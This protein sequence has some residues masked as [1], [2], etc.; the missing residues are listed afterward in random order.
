MLDTL[1]EGIEQINSVKK[2]ISKAWELS[3][4]YLGIE[5]ETKKITEILGDHENLFINKNPYHNHYHLAEVIFTSAVLLKAEV[6]SP[7]I[8]NHGVM[9]LFAATFHDVE[10][11]GR[12]NKEPF[13]AE[14]VSSTFFKQWWRNNS[15]FVE[16]IVSM[17][18]I[19]MEESIKELILF[20]EF[21]EGAKK[22]KE[23]YIKRKDRVAFSLEYFT[24]LKKIL[25]EAD[26]LLNFLPLTAFKKCSLI[27]DEA[28]KEVS[29]REKWMF[30]LQMLQTEAV[31]EFTSEAIDILDIQREI[32]KFKFFLE[33]NI[34]KFGDGSLQSKVNRKFQIT[35]EFI[36]D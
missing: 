5:Q 15:L 18:P 35:T 4:K 14:Q 20:T 10:H 25:S 26:L 21:N 7:F 3:T 9:I 17:N 29:E 24:P 13:E 19:D 27:I 1:Y 8:F 23:D 11:P 6:P 36:I 33:E 30:I 32:E 28:K 2:P 12:T 16:N 34:E 22:V 31:K